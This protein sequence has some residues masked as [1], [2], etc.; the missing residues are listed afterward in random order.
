MDDTVNRRD[1]PRHISES[2][3]RIKRLWN[4]KYEYHKDL[5]QDPAHEKEKET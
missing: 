5:V 4:H 3:D 2:L 1:A